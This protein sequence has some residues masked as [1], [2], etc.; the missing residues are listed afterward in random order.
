[1]RRPPPAP[2]TDDRKIWLK[3]SHE[4]R[5]ERFY[6]WGVD[7]YGDFHGGYLNFGLWEGGI[8]DYVAAAENLVRRCGALLGLDGESHLLDVACGM[9]TQDIFLWRQFGPKRIDALDVTWEH[10]EHGRARA[11]RWACE[12]RVRFH[13]GTATRLPFPDG[14]FTH[15]LCIE[16]IVHFDTREHFLREALRVLRPG[17]VIALADYTLKRAPRLWESVLLDIALS[18]WKVPRVN[19]VPPAA[20]REQLTRSGFRNIEVSEVGASTIPGYFIEQ[21]RPETIREISKRRGFLA[22]RLGIVI[23]FAV[24]L[25]HWRGVIDYVIVRAEKPAEAP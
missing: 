11:A 6:G 10:V 5:V 23:D 22:G 24:Y 9:G 13:H 19:F 17:G 14:H 20:Y 12:D 2:S 4:Y 25:G 18:L 16:G 21:R 3:T 15:V 8:S 1:M 7:G